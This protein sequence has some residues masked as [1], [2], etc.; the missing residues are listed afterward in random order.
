[1]KTPILYSFKR[2]PYAIRARMVLKLANIKCELREVRLNN[3]PDHMLEISPKGT[4]P[5]LI[6]E[7]EVIDES[8]EIINWV[9]DKID[10]F[11]GNIDQTQI[12]LT[13]SLISIFDDKF[14]YH[15][16]RYKYSNRYKDSDLEFHR[17]ACFQ[18]LL[19]LENIIAND[20][21]IFGDKLNKLDISILPFIR[22]YR[23]ADIIWFDAQSDINKVQKILNNFIDSSLFKEVMLNY[24]EWDE[25]SDPIYFPSS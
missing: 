21:W 5:V 22:Q 7:D 8:I 2:C 4:V 15:L 16:D 25:I 1:M 17:N 3:K 12:E 24:E 23:I 10:V 9:L 6:L 19:E 13:Q 14:K 11:K 20:A 18:I